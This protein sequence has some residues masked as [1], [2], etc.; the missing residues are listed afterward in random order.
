MHLEPIDH[1]DPQTQTRRRFTRRAF[2]FGG[3]LTSVAVL[4][5]C[6]EGTQRDAARGKAEDAERDSVLKDL[7]A[8]ETWNLING[9]PESTPV[10][11][12]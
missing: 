10:P 3:L 9:T 4:A 6:A 1:P 5:G 2:A 12:E 11:E 8:T 7:Q